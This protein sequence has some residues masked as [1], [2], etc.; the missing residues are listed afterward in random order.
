MR[1]C[2]T[3]SDG[4]IR[5]IGTGA[6]VGEDITEAEYNTIMSLIHD[7]PEAPA[8]YGYHLRA[9]LTFELYELP[10]A[11]DIDPELSAEEA[12]EIIMGGAV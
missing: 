9:D 8:G 6:G 11:E 12:L 3:I 4:Y 5:A 1:Y 10:A 2:K 7:K